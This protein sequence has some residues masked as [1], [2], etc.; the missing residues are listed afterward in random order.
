MKFTTLKCTRKVELYVGGQLHIDFHCVKKA[1]ANF[2]GKLWITLGKKYLR[3]YSKDGKRIWGV[4]EGKFSYKS[5]RLKAPY[6]ITKQQMYKLVFIDKDEVKSVVFFSSSYAGDKL[7]TLWCRSKD[8]YCKATEYLI[9][10]GKMKNAVNI[11]KT[12][13]I[14]MIEK[15]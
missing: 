7:Q 8:K 5:I 13:K 9:P 14:E 10:G 15:V 4:V 11:K 3:G 6:F 12:T 2:I 1:T